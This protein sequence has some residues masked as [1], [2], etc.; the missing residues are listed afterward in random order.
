MKQKYE[1]IIELSREKVF[2]LSIDISGSL[3]Y[4]DGIS[5]VKELMRVNDELRF[6]VTYKPGVLEKKRNPVNSK[7]IRYQEA[8]EL[9]IYPRIRGI[10]Q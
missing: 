1:I 9:S 5:A 6:M 4:V 10:Y 3:E 7:S 2:D 8:G